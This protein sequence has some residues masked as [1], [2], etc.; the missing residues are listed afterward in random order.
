MVLFA[1]VTP[2]FVMVLLWVFT[3][4][5]SHAFGSFVW[6]LLGFFFLPTTTM[7]F[8]VAQNEFDGTKGWGLVVLILGVMVD[9][10]LLGGGGRAIGRRATHE[11]R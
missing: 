3:N 7:A 11:S 8:A 6:P 10:G 1:L 4:Y 9:F 5:L 2:R